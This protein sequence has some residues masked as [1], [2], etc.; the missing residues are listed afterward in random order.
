M[1]RQFILDTDWFTDCDDCIALRF[2]LGNLD[3]KH[4]L[5]GI[6]VDATTE[7]SYAS[8]K[9]FLEDAGVEYPIALDEENMYLGVTRYQ[10]NMANGSI[11]T[12][13]D[14]EK[15]V[16]F[17]KR[18]LEQNDNV[19]ILSI[20]FLSSIEK[21][22]RQYP[23]LS[24]EK[25]K[26]IWVMGGKWDEEGGFE[27]N[28]SG[29]GNKFAINA[30]RFLINE[31]LCPITFLGFE[32]GATVITGRHLREK[33]DILFKAMEDYGTPAGRESW[34]PLLI[35]AGLD[36]K[37]LDCFYCIQGNAYIDEQGKNYFVECADGKHQYIVKTR[38]DSYYERIIDSFL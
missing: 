31:A 1:I 32:V 30:S 14:A 4:R 33:G 6:N 16:D 2:L 27:Y 25:I 19:E 24:R 37:Y 18:I 3:E 9:S 36:D 20:G 21:V 7:Y 26:R 34:D 11:Y 29:G 5:L 8:M 38:E 28:I 17:Y 12:N 35:M 15:S 23:E 22:F 13:Q 10:K